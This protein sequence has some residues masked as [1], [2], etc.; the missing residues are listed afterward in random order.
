M[1]D[2]NEFQARRPL[3]DRLLERLSRLQPFV[4]PGSVDAESEER[5]LRVLQKKCLRNRGRVRLYRGLVGDFWEP[6]LLSI[7]FSFL[8]WDLSR[9]IRLLLR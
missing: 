6:V 9:I 8:G 3:D 7:L 4:S 2:L 5:L 1:N